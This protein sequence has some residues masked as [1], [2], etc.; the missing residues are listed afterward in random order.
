LS[1][2][3]CLIAVKTGAGEL[4]GQTLGLVGV[5]CCV[6]AYKRTRDAPRVMRNR[7][8]RDALA[9]TIR[10]GVVNASEPQPRRR[11]A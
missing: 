4:V 5:I 8:P 2:V 10:M 3:T 11:S 6:V 1:I 7:S 9:R